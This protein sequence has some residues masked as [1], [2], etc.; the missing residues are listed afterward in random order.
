MYCGSCLND[1]TVARSWAREGVDIQLVPTYT[2]IRTDERDV[3]GER[4]FFGGIQVYLEQKFPWFRFAPRWLRRLVNSRRVI[5]WATSRAIQTD[6]R[7]LGALTVSMLQGERGRQRVDCEELVEWLVAERP[8]A[9]L[10]SNMLISGFVPRLRQ[11]LD[12]SVLV[13]LQGDDIFLDSLPEPYRGQALAELRR[14]A[15]HIDRFVAHSRYYADF[16]ASFAGLP[17]DGITVTPLGIDTQDF[18]SDG[19]SEGAARTAA[20][21]IGAEGMAES[22]GVAPAASAG[23]LARRSRRRIGYLARLAPE[24]GLHQ[25]VDAFIRLRQQRGHDDCELWIA[26]WL[27]AHRRDYA[28]EQWKKLREAGLGEDFCYVGELSRRE[29]VNFLRQLDIFSVP[30]TYQEPKGLFVLEALAAGVAVVEPRHGAFPELLG[31]VGGGCLFAPGDVA[32]LAQQL[33]ELLSDDGRR[34]AL[35]EAGQRA[36]LNERAATVTGRVLL[37]TIMDQVTDRASVTTRRSGMSQS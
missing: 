36:V 4:L 3:S 22:A 35:A 30:T 24:K 27:G 28:E 21:D 33:D 9:V 26:G 29:K 8:D 5:Q 32:E 19:K 10:L 23:Q 18:T 15:P 37:Q 2:P 13:M 1:N 16:M 20:V 31:A 34:R 12:C 14:L 6:A 17:R 11:R 25:L 7:D